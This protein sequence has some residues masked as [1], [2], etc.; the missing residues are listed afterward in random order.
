MRYFFAA[1]RDYL[2]DPL[3]SPTSL[4]TKLAHL[5]AAVLYALKPSN[6][7]LYRTRKD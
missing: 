5:P 3:F 2:T 7:A 6:R 4:R 1:V